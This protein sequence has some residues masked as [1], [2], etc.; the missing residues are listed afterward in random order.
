MQLCVT[1]QLARLAAGLACLPLPCSSSRTASCSLTRVVRSLPR[2]PPRVIRPRT[3]EHDVLGQCDDL[4]KQL[5]MKGSLFGGT[6]DDNP[7]ARLQQELALQEA[8]EAE[9][10]ADAEADA[11]AAQQQQAGSAGG[12]QQ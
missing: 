10:A 5:G 11:A 6:G 4:L 2:R 12:G 3:Q 7:L 1:L 8:L 9:L